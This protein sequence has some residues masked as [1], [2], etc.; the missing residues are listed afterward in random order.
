[1]QIKSKVN[2]LKPTD[3]NSSSAVIAAEKQLR[4]V[5]QLYEKQ[6]LREMVKQMRAS[7]GESEFMPAGFAEKYYREQLDHQYVES[8]GDQG[9]I[10]LG[11]LIYD[12]LVS[13]YGEALGLK[14][15]NSNSKGP[16]PLSQ[17][18]QWGARMEPKDKSIVFTKK[19]AV[20]SGTSIDSDV[21]GGI[22]P[23]EN[24]KAVGEVGVTSKLNKPLLRHE[25]LASSNG[26]SS[27]ESPWVG[28]W[29]GS[30]VLD[31][32]LKVA[33]IQHEG[34]QSLLVGSFQVA[35][36][37][38]GEMLQEGTPVGVLDAEAKQLKWKLLKTE[39]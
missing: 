12:Q 11:Q 3:L 18:D 30:F 31:N 14:L 38:V 21:S 32:G 13:K 35:P 4:N 6:F 9:G 39:N 28:R 26:P 17:K 23:A 5:S 2:P 7:V 37:K 20:H 8:W 15:P 10:G 24:V 27:F 22:I 34:F 1:M 16:L 29:L 33:K 36:L 25:K 19:E